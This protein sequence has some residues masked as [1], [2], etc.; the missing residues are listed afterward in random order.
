MAY[1]SSPENSSSYDSFN[2]SSTDAMMSIKVEEEES[3]FLTPS[4]RVRRFNLRDEKQLEQAKKDIYK[5][6]QIISIPVMRAAS[7]N[8]NSY[9]S[10]NNLRK[11]RNTMSKLIA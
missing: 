8:P 5:R 4:F 10:S 1:K 7:T 2:N 11:Q 3:L 9:S 6:Y